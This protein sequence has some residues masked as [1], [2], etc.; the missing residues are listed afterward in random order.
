MR[1]V[2]DSTVFFTD[3]PLSGD[4]YVSSS[5]ISELRDIRAKSR[6]DT[7]LVQGLHVR[8]PGRLTLKKAEEAA[9]RTG[10][11]PV[12]SAT[13]LDILALAL[14]EGC[15][16]MTDDYAVQNVAIE[17]GIPVIPVQQRSAK[18]IR[19]RFRCLGCGRYYDEEGECPVC[20]SPVK[21]KLK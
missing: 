12:L 17:L 9:R 8:E 1:A 10:D 20:G 13:D 6:L 5:V 11:L 4:L 21:R 7:L 19:W 3:I 2:L 16:I 15:G 18:S 14:E